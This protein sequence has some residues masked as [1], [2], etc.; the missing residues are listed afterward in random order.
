MLEFSLADASNV[1]PVMHL[2]HPNPTPWSSVVGHAAKQLGVPL[3]PYGDWLQALEVDI[4]D[5]SKTEVQHMREN[6]ALRLLGFFREISTIP[7]ISEGRPGYEAMGVTMMDMEKA[8]SVAP[9][10]RSL[11]P[12]D[13][14]DMDRWLGYWRRVGLLTPQ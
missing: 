12:L 10:L 2:A 14:E 4:K 8:K 5:G 1:P 6:P 3:V 13:C 11:A 9:S 7:F